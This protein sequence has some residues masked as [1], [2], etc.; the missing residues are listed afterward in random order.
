MKKAII[1][2]DTVRNK[3]QVKEATIKKGFSLNNMDFFDCNIEGDIKD[4]L[5]ENC[6]IRNS[7]MQD[8]TIYSNNDIKYSNLSN[9]KYGGF[10]NEI[11]SSYIDSNPDNI[12]NANLSNCIVLN[13]NFSQESKIDKHTELIN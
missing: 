4:C 1:N 10:L 8:S 12:I 7:N 13:G 3:V 9:C 6:K 2:F 5:F 11:R